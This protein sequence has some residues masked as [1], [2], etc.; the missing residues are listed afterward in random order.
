MILL[1]EVLFL[2]SLKLNARR[3]LPISRLPIAPTVDPS[4]YLVNIREE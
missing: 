2:L 4:L 3:A 1:V